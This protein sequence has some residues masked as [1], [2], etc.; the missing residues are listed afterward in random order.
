MGVE[1]SQP[2]NH[3]GYVMTITT[4]LVIFGLALDEKLAAGDILR[5]KSRRPVVSDTP[6]PACHTQSTAMA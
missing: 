2:A 4:I 3:R 6:L 5:C 1:E